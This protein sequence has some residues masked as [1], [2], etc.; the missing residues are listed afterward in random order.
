MEIKVYTTRQMT[1]EGK[2][3]TCD[4]FERVFGTPKTYHEFINQFENNEIGYSYFGQIYDNNKL[5]GSYAAIPLKFIYFGK[6]IIFAQSVDTMIDEEHRGN[7]FLLKKL[8]EKVYKKLVED[9][10]P[11]VFGFPNDN[12]YLVRKKVLKWKDI[13]NLDIYVLPV[14]I[15][16]VKKQ[17]NAFNA[18]SSF[19]AKLVNIGINT[20]SKEEEKFQIYKELTK[21]YFVYR[22]DDEYTKI[23]ISANAFGYYR[24]KDFNDINTAFIVDVYPLTKTNI[25]T[26][27]KK[28]LKSNQN[29]DLVAYFGYLPFKPQNL[30]KIP[31]IYKPKDTFM[32]G[33][34]LDNDKIDQKIFDIKNWRVNLSN[35]DWI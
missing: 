6:E 13:D 9:S 33:R 27:V 24:L 21:E 1:E 11:F 25:E 35:F 23:Q 2:K 34:I 17:L 20:Y 29:I 3:Q 19:F 32:S 22:F 26:M 31:D 30:F 8:A 16:A 4:L 15:G 5:I 18:I 14:H 12:I 7:P 10:I 28:V